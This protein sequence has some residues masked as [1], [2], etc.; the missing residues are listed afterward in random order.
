MLR[1]ILGAIVGYVATVI[2]VI[3]SL[4][5]TW[6]VLGASGSFTGEGPYPSPAWNASAL[7]AG[8]IA[9]LLGGWVALKVGRA[10]LAVKILVG[11]MLVLGLYGAL[12]AENSYQKR[13]AQAVDK[14]VADLS[15]MEAGAVAK[16][17]AWYNWVIPFVG[18]T[19]ALLGGRER[20]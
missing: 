13:T 3:A 12:T 20:G 6:A 18:A 9:A 5:V 1:S 19:G 4:A 14:Q 11:M 16:N 8:F 2:V 10:A 15:F 7:V 17:P